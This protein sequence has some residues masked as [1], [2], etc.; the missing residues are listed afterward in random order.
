MLRKGRGTRGFLYLVFLGIFGVSS[1]GTDPRA[2]A[3]HGG[4]ADAAQLAARRAPRQLPVRVRQAEEVHLGPPRAPVLQQV[5]AL[6]ACQGTGFQGLG[7]HVSTAAAGPR[8]ARMSGCM[9]QGSGSEPWPRVSTP[10]AVRTSLV[11]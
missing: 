11:E 4:E 1:L 9:L 5:R 8:P 3:L 7:P 2:H 6:P 10:A